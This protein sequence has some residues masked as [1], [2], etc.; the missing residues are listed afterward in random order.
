M[1]DRGAGSA[2]QDFLQLE[3]RRIR[4]ILL[5]SSLFDLYL[6]EEEGLQFELTPVSRG[7]EAL[8]LLRAGQHFDL[9]ITT[10]HVEDMTP[11]RLAREIRAGG[12]HTPVVLLAYDKRE[13]GEIA[14]NDFDRVFIWRGDVRLLTTII[15]NIEDEWNAADD[16]KSFG[17]PVI[18]VNEDS[19]RYTSFFLPLLYSEVLE[20][21]QRLI[22]EGV[23]KVHRALRMRAR[24]KIL[25]SR[26]WEEA[27]AVFDRFE[28]YI[29]GV[30]TDAGFTRHGEQNPR[31]GIELTRMVK[32]RRWDVPVLLQSTNPDLRADANQAGAI[33]LW[34][35]SPDLAEEFRK[36][37][38]DNFG[39]GDFIFRLDGKEVGRAHD[40]ESLEEQLR[41]VP[42]SSV[43]QHAHGND[44][45]RWFQARTE[46]QLAASLRPRQD[47]EWPTA[48]ALREYL[49]Q[50]VR[51]HRS[52]RQ[53]GLLSEFS[54]KTFDPA[55]S[56]AKTGE[57]S[58][59]G[60]AR[61]I[62][63][64]N[65][66]LSMSERIAGIEIEVPPGLVI[67]TKVFDDFLDANGLRN[68][69]GSDEEIMQRFIAAEHFPDDAKARLSEF[70]ELCREPLAVRSSSLL[71]DS[72]FHPFAGVYQTYMIP[73]RGHSRLDELLIAIKRVYASTFY[74]AARHYIRS[75]SL[76]AEDEKMAVIVQRM[77]GAPHGERFYPEV[78]GVARSYNFYPVGPQKP[79]DGMAALALGLG[80]TIVEG[81]PAVRFSPHYPEHL[82]EEKVTQTRFYA[83]ELDE[84]P[85]ATP[86]AGGPPSS[87]DDER[88][89]A[90][91]L[92]TAEA[93]GTLHAVASTYSA[94]NDAMYDGI[95]RDGTRV[96]TFAPILRQKLIPLAEALDYLCK[97]GSSGIGTPVEIEFAVDLRA[98]KLGVL[99]M[100]PLVL[101]RE[102][103]ALDL[104]SIPQP[105]VLCR[106]TQ[107]LGHGVI[108]DLRDIV[109]IAADT[110]DRSRSHDAAR[111]IA[112]L[113]AQLRD[114]QRDYLLIGPGRWGSNDPLLGIPVKWDQISGAR[115]IVES[116]F[117]D[118]S[119]DPS[120]GSHFFQN[121][122]AFQVGY[123][124]VNPRVRNSFVDW[125]WL[126]SQRA[127]S[128]SALVRHVRLDHG[129]TVTMNGR[130]RR[131][132][133]VKPSDE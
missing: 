43:R 13:L 52:Q 46:F 125:P 15:K 128:E 4:D 11:L 77:V 117:R 78:S 119:V 75:T 80:R 45:S 29:S 59:G 2:L 129:V 114:E 92:R 83:L 90:H 70:L 30:I 48:D 38:R 74:R 101:N 79:E 131:G 86:A 89:R 61:G 36:T 63:F 10:L 132:V 68:V 67:A 5:V 76:R 106:S 23:N 85:P 81:A 44:F 9:V 57:G 26:S 41:V 123:F 24:P 112:A 66:L 87:I 22:G 69:S 96:V 1:T 98:R 104:E 12:F 28:P 130:E 53:R 54:A 91:D 118:L 72:Q 19:V 50:R 115:A 60:K 88:I 51:E 73:N 42:A 7:D 122:T 99:Q 62:A 58:I 84:R 3:R 94:E 107:V 110:F 102:M 6:F 14:T 32:Q 55:T 82:P 40:L 56:F 39:F 47:T 103:E 127:V 17:V 121:L 35:E 18:L 37:F 113:N 34:K 111:E 31:A 71:E 20:H 16:T 120:Q 126:A 27:A 21:A 65:T 133:I 64:V 97:L 108:H 124:S 116:D 100:R 33:Y 109:V 8:Q 93:D 95:S 49:A 105:K 25:L